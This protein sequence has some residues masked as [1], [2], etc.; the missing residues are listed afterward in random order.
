MEE[1]RLRVLLFNYDSWGKVFRS[2]ARRLRDASLDSRQRSLGLTF[3]TEALARDAGAVPARP[4]RDE[5]TSVSQSA[6]LKSQ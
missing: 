3:L 1:F 6:D 2:A 4:R 5:C